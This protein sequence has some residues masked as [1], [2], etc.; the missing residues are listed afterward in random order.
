VKP[1]QFSGWGHLLCATCL[2][3]AGNVFS[4][5]TPQWSIPFP[6]TMRLC[7][8]G[9]CQTLTWNEGHYDGR[10]DGQTEVTMTFGIVRWDREAVDIT[11]TLSKPDAA[12][13]YIT[14]IF[15]GNISPAG[16][17][18]ENGTDKWRAGIATGSVPFTMT[19][20]SS[21]QVKSTA[22]GVSQSVPKS[23]RLCGG[24]KCVVLKLNGGNYD[25][26]EEN[27]LSTKT[28]TYIVGSFSSDMVFLNLMV[29]NGLRAIVTG[30]VQGDT[31]V[32]GRLT[33]LNG[34]NGASGPMNGM[35]G[36]SLASSKPEHREGGT[37]D[38]SQ[39]PT[40]SSIQA[41]TPSQAAELVKKA[42]KLFDDR[43][44]NKAFPL[45]VQAA[46]SGQPHAQSRLGFYYLNGSRFKR[47]CKEAVRRYHLGDDSGDI[48]AAYDIGY[49]YDSGWC[50]PE[51][52]TEALRWYRRASGE[53]DPRGMGQ[54]GIAY[55]E[56][57]GVEKDLRESEK[58]FQKTWTL[59]NSEISFIIGTQFESDGLQ[60]PAEYMKARKWLE[61]AAELGNVMAMGPLARLY[62]KGL[63][64]PVNLEESARWYNGVWALDDPD[65]SIIIGERYLTDAFQDPAN[66]VEARKW[67]KKSAG[68]GNAAAMGGL[69]SLYEKGLGGPMD[70]DAAAHWN[71]KG[72]ASGDSASIFRAQI[73]AELGFGEGK[74]P[75]WPVLAGTNGQVLFDFSGTWQSYFD[76]YS[77]NPVFIRIDQIANVFY[78]YRVNEYDL[79]PT[80]RKVFRGSYDPASRVGNIELADYISGA[81]SGLLGALA[82]RSEE[83]E[84]KP[85]KI[86][87]IDPDHLKL[88]DHP[89]IERASTPRLHD[90]LCTR[91]NAYHVQPM[92]ASFRARSA[93]EQVDF[94]DAACWSYIAATAG[95][96]RSM[97]KYGNL[98]HR[99]LGVNQD[100]AGAVEWLE[101][102]A[103]HGD[104]YGAQLLADMYEHGDGVPAD[105][106]KAQMWHAKSAQL[107][108]QLDRVQ[109]E[110]K[111]KDAQ[112]QSDLRL[113]FGVAYVGAEVMAN[114]LN[115]SP[116]CDVVTSNQ[117]E[118]SR[119]VE[120]RDKEIAGG[121]LDCSYK[122]YPLNPS[123]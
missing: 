27:N 34:F 89:I 78:A 30:K 29:P 114:E 100:N 58:Q 61:K 96:P 64:G 52:H 110:E 63:G 46:D 109:A 50:V 59:N 4:Q 20:N 8:K 6:S 15:T 106:T 119:Q 1:K 56:G 90:V 95:W 111:R 92:F 42:D 113:L 105:E 14:G 17:S 55:Y 10:L 77:F 44:W 117:A 57:S 16:N 54:M 84:W 28:A 86:T 76:G 18:L 51:S 102:G 120:E 121:E 68:L 97:S 35:W 40:S 21:D 75:A 47:D 83:P 33:W 36:D 53:G 82:G 62:E 74:R 12:G 26:Y 91:D 19:W 79:K 69:S 60:K 66:F 49:A 88:G 108:A 72:A 115:R 107:K 2:L 103:K 99:G 98:L 43:E 80:G 31:I 116:R 67:L 85:M 41:L 39:E 23:L 123:N 13:S 24:G 70:L 32:N 71:N 45:Y 37:H 112:Y 118:R 93:E 81:G 104:Y 38:S 22:S 122:W 11:G 48:Q 7:A 3:V 101:K 87:I 94:V 25:V 9:V 73:F 65:L 5:I